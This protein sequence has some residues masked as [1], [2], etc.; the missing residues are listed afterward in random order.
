MII[1]KTT[2]ASVHIA[3]FHRRPLILGM[4]IS[5]F[6]L[7]FGCTTGLAHMRA[8][9]YYPC[10]RFGNLASR[11]VARERRST[12]LEMALLESF[13]SLVEYAATCSV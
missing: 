8:N 2:A 11:C 9:L 4:P 10:F 1:T 12:P 13:R 6:P 5:P 7:V 3:V